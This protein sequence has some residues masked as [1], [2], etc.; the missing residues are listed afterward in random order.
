[1]SEVLV[2]LYG[3]DTPEDRVPGATT[4]LGGKIHLNMEFEEEKPYNLSLE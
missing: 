3:N 2:V 1:M 4:V